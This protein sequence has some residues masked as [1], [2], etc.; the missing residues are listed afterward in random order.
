MILAT[1]EMFRAIIRKHWFAHS[2]KLD[3]YD[4]GDECLID[5]LSFNNK[6]QNWIFAYFGLKPN[7]IT[8]FW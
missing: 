5:T 6:G 4:Q 7:A 8:V 2:A 1:F 3:C